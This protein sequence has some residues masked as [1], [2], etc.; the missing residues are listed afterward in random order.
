MEQILPIIIGCS[1]GISIC[2]GWLV[3]VFVRHLRT[4]RHP[5]QEVFEMDDRTLTVKLNNK[6][7]RK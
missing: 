5:K 3:F 1:V 2:L 7:N 4:K 6:K